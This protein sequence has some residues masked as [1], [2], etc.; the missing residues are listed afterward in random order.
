MQTRE[1]RYLTSSGI[2]GYYVEE[3]NQSGLEKV[4]SYDGVLEAHAEGCL[5]IGRG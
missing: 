2:L 5:D 4:D 3:S 1:A